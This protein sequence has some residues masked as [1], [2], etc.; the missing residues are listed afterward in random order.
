M[1]AFLPWLG[2][3][4]L[5]ARRIVER[6]E[7]V[8]HTCYCE[9]FAG[10]AHVLFRKAPSP[11]EALND[12]D[13]ELVTLF[14][15]LQWHLEEF[16]RY[17]KWT[18][19]SRDE[20]RRLLRV[21]PDTLTDIQRA[22]RFYYLQ[23]LSFGGRAKSR[24]FGTSTTSPPRLN[25]LRLEEELSAV[26]VR[27]AGVTIERLDWRECLRRYDRPHTL[28]YLDPPYLGSEDD[29]GRGRFAREDFAE[30]RE[31]LDGLQGQWLLSLNDH[32]EVRRV[33]AGLPMQEVGVRYSVARKGE[34]RGTRPELLITSKGMAT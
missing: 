28:F 1:Q 21:E 11:A 5:L 25:L 31:R 20:F 17:F 10:A 29:Y 34:G 27:L 30:L 15:V 33:F 14:R 4:R 26:H 19:V 24:S 12:I 2:G 7:Q 18:V 16:L 32:P 3:K 22:A 9:P 13:G 8:E 23:K 6:I